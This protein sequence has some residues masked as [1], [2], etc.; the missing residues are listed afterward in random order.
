[1]DINGKRA[2]VT[3]STK[4]IGRAIAEA[5]LAGGAKVIISARSERDVNETVAALSN[6]GQDGVLGKPCDVSKAREVEDLVDFAVKEWGGL[7]I[8]INNAG[9]GIF[10]PVEELVT[11]EWR[12]TIGTNL[13]GLFYACRA[14]IPVMKKAGGGF[15]INIGSL[16]GKNAFAGGAAYNASKFGLIGFSEALMQ[17]V[18]HDDILVAYIMPGSVDTEFGSALGSPAAS[19]KIAAS[20][21]AEV[22]I[23]TLTRHPRCLTSRIEMRPSKPPRK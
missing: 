4:G 21:V 3:G 2:I 11:E 12:Q 5:L 18:R 1:M 7:E 13:D 15:I 19:W 9:L 23:Q 22:V 10:K 17:E 6:H 16:A 20:D 8:L 14:A